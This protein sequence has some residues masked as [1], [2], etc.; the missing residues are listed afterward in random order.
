MLQMRLRP[1]PGFISRNEPENRAVADVPSGASAPGRLQ[2]V[3]PRSKVVPTGKSNPHLF[4]APNPQLTGHPEPFLRNSRPRAGWH[5][6]LLA[7]VK[8]S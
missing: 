6:L 8:S 5:V 4:D 3:M 1:F 7:A 2:K